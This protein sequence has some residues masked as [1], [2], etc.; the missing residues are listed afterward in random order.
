MTSATHTPFNLEVARFGDICQFKLT[1]GKQ[2]SLTARLNYPPSLDKLYQDWLQAYLN[3][4]QS[5]QQFVEPITPEPA[6][7]SPL[8]ARVVSSGGVTPTVDWQARL[9]DA[10]MPLLRGFQNWLEQGE[11]RDIRKTI[12]AASRQ[13]E[14]ADDQKV[15]VFLICDPIDLARLPWETWEVTDD[16]AA[17]GK[18]RIARSPI[19]IRA[20]SATV[21]KPRWRRARILA[22][23]CDDVGLNLS[24][25]K[26]ILKSLEPLVQV[27]FVGWATNTHQ[28]LEQVRQEIV[29][30]IKDERGWDIL[31]FAGHSDETQMTGGRLAIAPKTSLTIEELKPYLTTA[32]D[33]GLQLAMFN[34]CSGL[35]IAESLIDL[36]LNQVVV[37]R[38]RIHNQVAQEFLVQFARSLKLYKD[39]HEA[40]RDATQL[41]SNSR[42]RIQYPSAYLVPSLFRR[43]GSSLFHLMQPDWR[44]WLMALLPQ[45]RYELIAVSLLSVISLL[46][47]VQLGLLDQ[48]MLVQT[49]YR[50]LTQQ[51]EPNRPELALIRIDDESIHKDRAEIGNPNPMSHKY[52]GR[53][54]QRLSEQNVKVIG[55]DYIL[56]RPDRNSSLLA[57]AVKTATDRGTH[58]IF[59]KTPNNN[60]G[61]LQTPIEIADPRNIHANAAGAQG[62]D[63]HM[64]LQIAEAQQG[65]PISYWLV[66]FHRVCIQAQTPACERSSIAEQEAF[67]MLYARENMPQLYQSWVSDAAYNLARQLWFHPISDFSIPPEQVYTE[68]PAWK[69]LYEPSAPELTA[70]AQQTALI[71]SGGYDDAG[72]VAGDGLE[73]FVPPAAIQYWYMQQNPGNPHR[74]MTGGESLAYLFDHFL[75][76]RFVM[77]V[78]DLLMVLV[79]AILGKVAVIGFQ[80][81]PQKKLDEDGLRAAKS[82]L[83]QSPETFYLVGGTL[84]YA[85][86]SLQ[87]YISTLAILLPIVLPSLMFWSY[88]LPSLVKKRQ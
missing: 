30:A 37:M 40:V 11:L 41:L 80:K 65:L 77:P 31:F 4:Y 38:E 1:W 55:V 10:E 28:S 43:P 24:Q 21:T 26:Q 53:L 61:W 3:F 86:L 82:W 69:L 34:S 50:E 63:F 58:L 76:Q 88:W 70:I 75:D 60:G 56:D 2:Q 87:L 20:E 13:R 8:R 22:I 49:R 66:W 71:A 39:V 12:A 25:E 78:P 27:E 67:A 16:L 68:I 23:C 54:I 84:A 18:I 83:R 72:V 45:K 81:R 17:T 48:R 46:P 47:P 36:G 57:Q 7:P 33:R 73:N 62:S 85:L 14:E 9:I 5:Q 44:Q 35:R 79:A 74:K 15:D 32:K 19:T 51:I 29:E 59:A 52:M 6:E 64:P 42:K